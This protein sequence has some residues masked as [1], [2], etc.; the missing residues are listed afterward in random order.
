VPCESNPASFPAEQSAVPPE[1]LGPLVDATESVA[2]AARLRQS[3]IDN[4]YVFLRGVLDGDDVLH[5]RMEIFERLASVGEIRHPPAD[6][7][8]TGAS[9]R[10]ELAGDLHVFW[11]SV[12]E[13]PLLRRVT[14]GPRLSE[15]VS[16]LMDAPVRPHEYLFVRPAPVGTST[17]L[18]YDNPYFAGRSAQ[19]VTCWVPLG[20]IPICE[21]PLVIVEG[22]H[23]LAGPLES[24]RF[25]YD[26]RAFA[27][28]KHAA[29]QAMAR[30]AKLLTAQF[31]PGDLIVFS[32]FALHGSLENQSP[33]GRVR[34]SVDVRY[35]PAADPADDARYFGPNPLGANGQGYG[36]QIAAQPLATPWQVPH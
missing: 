4:G 30:G 2:D 11:K 3:L 35:Q 23:L 20:E 31:Q 17:D 13:G 34:L 22:S 10:L 16:L 32:G 27:A 12:S 5:A 6:G 9:R 8:A 19:I 24:L 29:Y 18:H 36:G 21:G 15:L 25:T 26:S 14:H 33:I 7:I 28:A 1:F